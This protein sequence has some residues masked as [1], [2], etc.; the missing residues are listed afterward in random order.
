MFFLFQL[1][2]LSL[3]V[4]SYESFLLSRLLV[5]YLRCRLVYRLINQAAIIAAANNRIK[6]LIDA[7]AIIATSVNK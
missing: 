2:L 7:E 6:P 3:Y 4:T 1:F 5:L